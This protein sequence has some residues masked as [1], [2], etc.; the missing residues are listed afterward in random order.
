[1]L[2][3]GLFDEAKHQFDEAT[4][5]LA[6]TDEAELAQRF[7]GGPRAAAHSLRAVAAWVTS[8]F[9]AAAR[10]AQEAVAEAEGADDAMTKGYVYGWAVLLAAIR[11]DVTLTGFNS[12]RLLNVV[13]DTGLR[14]WAPAAEQFERW[15]RSMLGG[16]PFSASELR[17][18]RPV[19]KE[20]GHDKLVTPVIG[21]LAAEAEVRN[22]RADEALALLGELI[23]EVRASG[24][25]WHEAELLRLS[26]EARLSGPSADPDRAGRDLEAAIAVAHE[27]GARAFELRAALSL[28][29]LYRSTGRAADAHA[30]LAPT[31]AGF[32]PTPNFPE[33]AEAQTLLAEVANS[34]EVKKEMASRQRRLKLQTSLGEAMIHARGHGAPETTAAFARAAD[35]AAH[36]EDAAESFSACYGLWTG[37]YMRGDRATQE[38]SMAFLRDAER[39]PRSPEVLVGHRIVGISLRSEGDYISARMHLEQALS[40]YDHELHGSLAFRYGVDSRISCT[41]YLALTLW[42]LGEIERAKLLAEE[43]LA[44]ARATGHIA[45]V[46]YT[47]GHV[48]YLDLLSRD[49]RQLQPHAKILV[50]LSREHELRMW[51]AISVFQHGYALWR[52]GEVDAGE[53]HMRAGIAAN[54]EQ[55]NKRWLPLFQGRLAEIEAEAKTIDG[56]LSRIEQALGLADETGEHWTDA[57]LHRLRGEILLR[58]GPANIAPAEEA[59]LT[60]IAIAQQQKA[61]SFELQAAHALAKLYQSTGRAANAHA[62]LSPA[63][64]RFS[65]TPEFPEIDQAQTLLA[66][67]LS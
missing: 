62:I 46:A 34:E 58:R 6:S 15:S 37:S 52:S 5:L 11:R 13:A 19:L 43:A 16:G 61:R 23:A 21:V 60:A 4:S 22:G 66:A 7:N 42:P 24:L 32:S 38:L 27:Q 17:A 12:R 41:V 57:F 29:K 2:Y 20:V 65:P 30:V 8:D 26:G 47:L 54:I 50:E 59:F 28:A 14:A 44:A 48:C 63:L 45:T 25:R 35:L 1:L 49:S 64:E 10:Y 31:L 56:A 3:G 9:D 18:A 55:G 53:A 39:L 40:A 51:L 67:L 36:L 33:I